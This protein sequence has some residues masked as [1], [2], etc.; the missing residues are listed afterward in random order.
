M[1]SYVIFLYNL[2]CALKM[3]VYLTLSESKQA[4]S[5]DRK[6]DMQA[7]EIFETENTEVL[8]INKI[9]SKSF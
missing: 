3:Y 8:A 9:H 6:T 1:N 4:S 7:L 2:L 5:G